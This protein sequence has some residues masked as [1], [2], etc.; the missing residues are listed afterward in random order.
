M[1]ER[2]VRFT[3]ELDQEN[4][5]YAFVSGPDLSCL[6]LLS[7]RPVLQP[8]VVERFI[9]AAKRNGFNTEELIFVE[10]NR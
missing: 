1:H 6:R 9:E 8:E 7:R 3:F 10:Q 2:R 4:Y 5:Q